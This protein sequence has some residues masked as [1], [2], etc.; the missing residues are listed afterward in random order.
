MRALNRFFTRLLN[1]ATVR[2][3]DERLKQEMELHIAA[4]TEENIR[5]CMTPDMEDSG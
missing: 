5:A 2:W 1:F 3:A 4:Q